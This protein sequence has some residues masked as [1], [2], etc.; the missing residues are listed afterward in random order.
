MVVA[1]NGYKP[2][3]VLAERAAPED[4]RATEVGAVGPAPL[5]VQVDGDHYK[6]FAIQPVEYAER[7]K[8]SFLQGNAVKYITRFKLKNGKA[9]LLKAK[10]CIDM[11][12]QLEYNV[13]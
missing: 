10:H 13:K 9:D 8:L 6:S 4:W 5:E 11:L 2:R 3:P 1:A 12:I 7:N